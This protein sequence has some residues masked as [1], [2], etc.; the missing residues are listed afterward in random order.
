[1]GFEPPEQELKWQ[2]EHGDETQIPGLIAACAL[3]AIASVI[4]LGLRFLSLR[5][6]HGRIHLEADDWL[7]LI[8]W[9]CFITLNI[10]WAAGTRYGIGRHAA[11][12]TNV[13]V[14]QSL[15]VVGEAT[16]ILAIA[17]IKFSVLALYLKTFSAKRCRYFIW[18]VGIIVMGWTMSGVVVAIFQ[19]TSVRYIWQ[20][21]VE[22]N[23]VDFGLRNLISGVLN[24]MINILI[25]VVIPFAW[26]LHITKQKKWLIL[27]TFV[28]GT[29][30]CIISVVRLPYSIQVGNDGPWDAVPTFIISL[31]EIV[32][33]M[34][35]ISI[36]A[37]RPIFEHA[38][39]GGRRDSRS[40]RACRYKETMHI[41]L[42]GEDARTHVNVTSPGTHNMRCDHGGI[43]VTK[44]IELVRHA[45]KSG[46]WVRVTDDEEHPCKSP[47][48]DK[49]G[50]S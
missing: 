40:A 44:N 26:S 9:L 7:V 23:C 41:G 6:L 12:A 22:G 50:G 1:M 39:G 20:P 14:T 16:Y 24:V 36:P 13:S 3:T 31:I 30:A 10:S 19:C 5:L 47:E 45:K 37:Y 17:F 28:T 21:D 48:Q 43:S 49:T 33:S 2:L 25:V 8:A 42:S 11:V 27:V 35:A 4:I 38:F 15:A 34:L 29:S 18:A 32:M 46:N